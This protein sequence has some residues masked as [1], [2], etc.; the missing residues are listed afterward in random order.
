MN[1][2]FR[3]SSR[4]VKIV[5]LFSY[6]SV[7]FIIARMKQLNCHGARNVVPIEKGYEPHRQKCGLITEKVF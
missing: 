3:P 4:F 6:K 1:S 7:S 5:E 2:I